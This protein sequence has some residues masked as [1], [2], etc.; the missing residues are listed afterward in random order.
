GRLAHEAHARRRRVVEATIDLGNV[1]DAEGTARNPDGKIADLLDRLE[2]TR[3]AQLHPV[4]GGLDEARCA[5][6]ILR[7][8]RL[9]HG[10][11]GYAER[12]RLEVGEFDPDLLVLQTEQFDLADA[13]DPLQ[14]QL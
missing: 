9:M 1:A 14:L 8:E 13:P 5:H 6:R 2:V 12:G 3:H 7:L 10:L 11:Q 4:A